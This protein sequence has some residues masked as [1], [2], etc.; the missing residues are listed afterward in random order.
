MRSTGQGMSLRQVA[1]ARLAWDN[2]S[3]ERLGVC[4]PSCWGANWSCHHYWPNCE[5]DSLNAFPTRGGAIA[6]SLH[7][8]S[9]PTCRTIHEAG[10]HLF[11]E[12]SIFFT[13]WTIEWTNLSKK[14]SDAIMSFFILC[15][16]GY[17]L[18]EFYSLDPTRYIQSTH[19]TDLQ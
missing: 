16:I 4:D 6:A 5:L 2:E 18:H 13:D 19:V 9:T 1:P 3:G 8:H 10:H 11:T 12:L 15:H 17:W 7:L 14:S